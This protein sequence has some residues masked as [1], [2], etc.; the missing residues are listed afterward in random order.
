M[1]E[2][3]ENK[4]EEKKTSFVRVESTPTEKS[5]QKGAGEKVVATLGDTMTNIENS[6]IEVVASLGRIEV[7]LTTQ[8]VV[9]PIQAP[10][11]APTNMTSTVPPSAS[12]LEK[13]KNVIAQYI[14]GDKPLITITETASNYSVK[15]NGFAGQRWTEVA[16]LI[17]NRSEFNGKW[18]SAGKDSHFEIP[19]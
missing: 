16:K 3:E 7:F 13:L 10:V 4:Q 6:L 19:K 11:S 17:G 15:F 12:K 14:S 5:P 9:A 1:S 18:I 8:P 2:N